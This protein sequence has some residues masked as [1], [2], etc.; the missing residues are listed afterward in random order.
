MSDE[1]ITA[2]EARLRLGVSRGKMTAM[3]KAGDLKWVSDPR[4]SRAKLIRVAD[5]EAWRVRDVRGPR[6]RKE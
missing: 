3:L 6:K 2:T 1:Y 5:V 4:N